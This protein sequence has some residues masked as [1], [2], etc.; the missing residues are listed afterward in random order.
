MEN[1]AFEKVKSQITKKF[2]EVNKCGKGIESTEAKKLAMLNDQI[3]NKRKHWNRIN[4]NIHENLEKEKSNILM[5]KESSY[6]T[7]LE[8]NKPVSV[9]EVKRLVDIKNEMINA[10]KRRKQQEIDD[11]AKLD[12]TFKPIVQALGRVENAVEKVESGVKHSER[13]LQTT[14]SRKQLLPTEHIPK[15]IVNNESPRLKNTMQLDEIAIKFLPVAKD[16]TFG[17]YYDNAKTFFYW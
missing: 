12:K 16:P 4:N 9:T 11:N 14:L 3:V 17:I 7:N 1:K 10:A 15:A 6:N 2:K 5:P 8:I 13:S